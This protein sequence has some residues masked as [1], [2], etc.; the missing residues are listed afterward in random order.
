MNKE[1]VELTEGERSPG[2][3]KKV[4]EPRE[5][6]TLL[7]AKPAVEGAGVH[8][9]RAFG[10]QEVPL[11]DPFLMLD[12][13]RSANPADYVQGFP[14]HPH[15]GIETITYVMAGEIE[16]LDSLG[17]HGRILP[18]DVQ[19]MTAGSGIVH[20]E[21]PRGD[22]EGRMEG[23]QLWANLPAERKMVAPRYRDIQAM[24]IPEVVRDNGTRIK[25]LC[26]E[27]DGV[28]GPVHDVVIDPGYLD[29]SMPAH[30]EFKLPVRSDDTVFAYIFAGEACFCQKHGTRAA[31]G[32][33]ALLGDGEQVFITTAGMACR[34]L[35]ISGRPLG[36]PV[37]WQGPVV[38][39]S[40]EELDLAFREVREGTFVKH[41]Q[42]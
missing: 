17:N 2:R 9:K 32:M 33:V 26:G 14:S 38:M 28:H 31:D 8:L 19:W 40:Q 5:V 6:K 25:V 41:Q 22:D 16:H 21:M 37:A 12:D 35:L 7:A 36:E 29:I 10:F 24:D 39:N 13:F 1:P 20:Q 42:T 34:F 18:G 3:E 23:F 11:F 15:R 30:A 4:S 27:V